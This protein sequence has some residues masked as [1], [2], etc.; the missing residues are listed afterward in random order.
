MKVFRMRM[1][2]DR[3]QT[4]ITE[5]EE[6]WE[7]LSTD[8]TPRAA[9]WSPPKVRIRN[10]HAVQG[11]FLSPSSG[12]PV[13]TD[14]AA[15][16]LKP[17]LERA[18]ELLP[19]PYRGHMYW[20]LNVT[21]C[22]NAVDEERSEYFRNPETGRKLYETTYV[23]NPH[24]LPASPL[25]KLPQTSSAQLLLTEGLLPPDEEFRAVVEREQL[26]GLVFD[27]LWS[28]EHDG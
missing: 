19:L 8:G 27:L 10:P 11:D 21:V 7:H 16:A 1:D 22:V 18:G 15:Q 5:Q 25:F 6:E 4:F 23:F 3:F 14:R 28:D 24:V 2:G 17:L 12:T 13:V 20:V 9:T 26:R